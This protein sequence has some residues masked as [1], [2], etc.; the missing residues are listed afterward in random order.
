MALHATADELA[1]NAYLALVHECHLDE[2]A[3]EHLF[4]LM[5]DSKAPGSREYQALALLATLE[6]CMCDH[7]A[8][9]LRR[10]RYTWDTQEDRQRA[11]AMAKSFIEHDSDSRW[12]DFLE[13][14]K[15]AIPQ[16]L[17]KYLHTRKVAPSSDWPE[18][19]LLV[20][21]EKALIAFVDAELGGR[22]GKSLEAVSSVLGRAREQLNER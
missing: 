9:V 18:L 10:H 21:H 8:A 11:T 2:L 12:A 20:D 22:S 14:L 1:S 13:N 4:E 15:D 3:G 16:F 19:D 6:H 5:K 17:G 7:L